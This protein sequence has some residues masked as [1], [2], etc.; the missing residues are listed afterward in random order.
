V[1]ATELLAVG[2]RAPSLWVALSLAYVAAGVAMAWHLGRLGHAP[3]TTSACLVVWPLL[4][5]LVGR[6]PPTGALDLGLSPDRV[7]E[8]GPNGAAIDAAIA[9]L[10]RTL[11]EDHE[12]PSAPL[13]DA[14]QLTSLADALHRADRRIARADRLLGEIAS[15]DPSARRRPGPE[16]DQ[17]DATIAELSSAR[18]HAQAELDA[19]LAGLTSL[20]LQLGMFALAGEVE[21]VRE[22]LAELEA[23]VAALA[24][25]SSIE[26]AR[27][28]S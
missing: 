9:S 28:R 16:R 4:L 24:E 3:G 18:G 17:L 8:R 19:V 10:A 23:R 12:G 5:G 13:L 15:E 1:S 14:A 22:R 7:G 26:L 25:L 20:R 2:L 27:V 11:R 6:S 21:P